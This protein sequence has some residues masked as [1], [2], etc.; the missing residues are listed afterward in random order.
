M[1]T[2][3]IAAVETQ[4]DLLNL[5]EEVSEDDRQVAG[6]ALVEKLVALQKKRYKAARMT[7]Q[8]RFEMYSLGFLLRG[9]WFD[10]GRVVFFS[11]PCSG[12]RG[13]R[14]P[15][16]GER[17]PRTAVGVWGGKPQPSRPAPE[18]PNKGKKIL[19]ITEDS[20]R[21]ATT[22]KRPRTSG[23][24]QRQRKGPAPAERAAL[25]KTR[26][27]GGCFPQNTPEV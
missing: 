4:L 7:A 1:I 15:H 27:S 24:G 26:G 13:E 23:K 5:N 22:K 16:A 19:N 20:K 6:A 10:Y 25:A 11:A 17:Q 9:R 3:E 21:H 14:K 12:P 8:I 18:T 2:Q